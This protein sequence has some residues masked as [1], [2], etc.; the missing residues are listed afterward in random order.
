M[1]NVKCMLLLSLVC[2]STTTLAAYL[3]DSQQPL[4]VKQLKSV[5]DDSWATVEGRLVQR[6]SDDNYLLRD[7]MGDEVTVE[8][9]EDVWRGQSVGPNELVRVSGEVDQDW[10][11]TKLDVDQLVKVGVSSHNKTGLITK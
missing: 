5:R 11:R 3:G 6:L 2:F 10:T 8:I 7:A 1:K 4:T 9:D